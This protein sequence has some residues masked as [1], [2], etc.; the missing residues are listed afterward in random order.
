MRIL[1]AGGAGYIGSVLVPQLLDHGYEVDVFDSLWF[2]NHLPS[3]AKVHCRELFLTTPDDFALYDQVV[4]LA[5]LSNDPMAEFSP[6]MN[7]MHNG[8]LPSYLAYTAKR[9]GV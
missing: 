9:A 8:A 7:F 5:G 2:G 3:E 1:V 6:A 4:F